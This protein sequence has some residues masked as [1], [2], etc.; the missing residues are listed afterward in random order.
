MDKEEDAGRYRRVRTTT[1]GRGRESNLILDR[2]ERNDWV[3]WAR[4][5][6]RNCCDPLI[7][8]NDLHIA[9]MFVSGQMGCENEA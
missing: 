1:C 9:M 5:K 2:C 4:D 3:D 8:L 7:T 6:D